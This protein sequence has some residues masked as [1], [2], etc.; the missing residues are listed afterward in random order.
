MTRGAVLLLFTVS[1]CGPSQKEVRTAKEARYKTEP[2]VVWKAI[3]DAVRSEYPR[4]YYEVTDTT[5]VSDWHLIERD[6]D[7]QAT[8]YGKRGGMNT[9]AG[10][11]MRVKITVAGPPWTISIEGEAALYRPGYAALI[12]YKRHSEEEPGWVDGRIDQLYVLIHD[13]LKTY[14]T[15]P[16]PPGP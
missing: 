2:A 12:P 13:K 1:A 15:A 10:K 5:L 9:K 3:T 14:E 16:T 8:E 7:D 6:V 4:T 11:F